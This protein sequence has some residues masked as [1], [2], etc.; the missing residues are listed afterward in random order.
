MFVAAH[1]IN[2][3]RA[4][5]MPQKQNPE[6]EFHPGLHICLS[7]SDI[8]IGQEPRNLDSSLILHIFYSAHPQF[9]PLRRNPGPENCRPIEPTPS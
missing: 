1:S 5:L 3:S 9:M 2:G 4:V 7:S 8:T 6:R